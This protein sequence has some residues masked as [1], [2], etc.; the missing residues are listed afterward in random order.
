M[1]FSTFLFKLYFPIRFYLLSRID[2][3][4]GIAY[5]RAAS[6]SDQPEQF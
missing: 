5:Y 4:G 3:S 6:G 2:A 1:R